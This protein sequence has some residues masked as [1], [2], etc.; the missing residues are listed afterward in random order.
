MN[1]T[2][3]ILYN[4]IPLDNTLRRHQLA[5]LLKNPTKDLQLLL[6]LKVHF[7]LPISKIKL[8]TNASKLSDDKIKSLV[9]NIIIAKDV[10]TINKYINLFPTEYQVVFKHLLSNSNV[11]S[12][13]N[14]I[15]NSDKLY[16]LSELIGEF[17]KDIDIPYI[18]HN[19]SKLHYTYRSDKNTY[20]SIIDRRKRPNVPPKWCY[21]TDGDIVVMQGDKS[22]L[23]Y[24]QGKTNT[25]TTITDLPS[26]KES[27]L[28]SLKENNI[29]KYITLL[30]DTPET[31]FVPKG[32]LIVKPIDWVVDNNYNPIGFKISYKDKIYSIKYK[33]TKKYL[34]LGL[35]RLLLEVSYAE[36]HS[37][38]T[39]LVIEKVMEDEVDGSQ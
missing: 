33:V 9:Y 14:I 17:K 20:S 38:L 37:R 26:I 15:Y 19:S 39:H 4:L 18:I 10:K 6:S 27:Q 2:F 28:Q 13:N 8:T 16:T 29:G 12:D 35:D 1:E 31:I 23:N 24:F 7:Q 30:K 36:K 5:R 11:F 3:Q 21:I 34:K 22:L 25:Y 32:C